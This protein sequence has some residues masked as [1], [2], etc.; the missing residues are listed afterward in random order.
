[1]Q[2]AACGALHRKLITEGTNR[3]IPREWFAGTQYEL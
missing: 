3:V 1:M 2:L